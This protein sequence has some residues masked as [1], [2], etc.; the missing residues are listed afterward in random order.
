[1]AYELIAFDIDGTMLRTGS[2]DD[3][4]TPIRFLISGDTDEARKVVQE[5]G[6][7]IE[8]I[9]DLHDFLG[10]LRMKKGIISNGSHDRQINKL[11]LSKLDRFF[12]YEHVLVSGK[13]ASDMYRSIKGQ[14]FPGRNQWTPQS[15]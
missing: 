4:P 12:D 1:M 11:V 5:R 2:K 9:G 13:V 14:D 10:S 6:R 3:L 7:M 8:P 15:E